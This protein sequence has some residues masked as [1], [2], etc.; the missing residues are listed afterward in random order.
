MRETLID[1][2]TK[3]VN[4]D[5]YNIGD[6]FQVITP[7]SVNDLGAREYL[8]RMAH[9]VLQQGKLFGCQL[10]EASITPCFVP[11]QVKCQ[12]A[13]TKLR[14]LIKTAVAAAEQS[15]DAGQ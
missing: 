8:T 12:I 13:D 9:Q 5:V 7:D 11:H 3:V 15:V 14:S 2:L 1:L 6:V 10:D 4:I